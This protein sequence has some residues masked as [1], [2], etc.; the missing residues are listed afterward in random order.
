MKERKNKQM[1]HA[2]KQ[3][4]SIL[5]NIDLGCTGKWI[6]ERKRR[7]RDKRRSRISSGHLHN[8]SYIS[9]LDSSAKWIH[10][11][12][13]TLQSI[14]A[15][16][17]VKISVASVHHRRRFKYAAT[18]VHST[19]CRNAVR[20]QVDFSGPHYMRRFV[21]YKGK[22]IKKIPSLHGL[23]SQHQMEQ[24]AQLPQRNS[25]STWNCINKDDLEWPW[26]PY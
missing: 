1:K 18:K 5:D 12:C 14:V 9:V 3:E 4:H 16:V 6:R 19:S 26:M 15:L 24:V 13:N 21:R 10:E 8:N 11:N 23:S 2:R 25:A 20:Y 7:K 17:S 22:I